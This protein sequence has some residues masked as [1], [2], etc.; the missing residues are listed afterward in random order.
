MKITPERLRKIIKEELSEVISHKELQDKAFPPEA[1][2]AQEDFAAI[3]D[4]LQS[5]ATKAETWQGKYEGKGLEPGD[6]L[7]RFRNI[8]DAFGLDTDDYFPYDD[9]YGV[10]DEDE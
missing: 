8:I 10:S 7:K 5:I 6:L 3:M 4:E 9:Q 1:R 2:K